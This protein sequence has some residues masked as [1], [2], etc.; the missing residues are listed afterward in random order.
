[1]SHVLTIGDLFWPAIVIVGIG[2][3]FIIIAVLA[4][5]FADEWRH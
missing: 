5:I 4:S 2:V 3:I 1:M